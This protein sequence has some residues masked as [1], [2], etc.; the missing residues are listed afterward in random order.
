[1]SWSYRCRHYAR[2]AA[3]PSYWRGISSPWPPSDNGCQV[4]DLPVGAGRVGS[5]PVWGAKAVARL[6]Q[7][8]AER[9]AMGE[10]G[11]DLVLRNHSWDR[12]AQD[13]W[14][15]LQGV[16]RGAGTP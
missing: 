4:P 11:S 16:A 6:V 14:E 3:T 1:M 2:A 8:P 13:T 9:R 10:R 15:I 7:D 5:G 12:R